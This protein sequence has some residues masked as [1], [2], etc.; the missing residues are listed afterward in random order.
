[1]SGSDTAVNYTVIEKLSRRIRIEIIR[2][3]DGQRAHC[4]IVGLEAEK[5]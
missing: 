2:R 1:V 4:K 3:N 5:R